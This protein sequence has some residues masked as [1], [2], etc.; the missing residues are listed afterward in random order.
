[1]VFQLYTDTRAEVVCQSLLDGDHA[2]EVIGGVS[3]NALETEHGNF[4]I[5]SKINRQPVKTYN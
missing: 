4:E 2:F 3:M 5:D 1:M